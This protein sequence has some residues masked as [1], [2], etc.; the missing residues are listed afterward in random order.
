MRIADKGTMR[1]DVVELIVSNTRVPSDAK[2]DLRA[3]A[4]ATRVAEREVLR[5]CEKYGGDTVVTAFEEVQDY[6]ERLTRKRVGELPDGVWETEDYIDFDPAEGEGLVPVKVKLEIDGEDA[7]LRPLRLASGGRD[8][9][10]LGLRHDVLGHRRRHQDVLPRRA[11]EL[12]LLPR[13]RVDAGEEN[14]VVNAAWPVAVTGFCSGGYEKVTNAVYELWSQVMPDRAMACCFNL[15]YLLVGG[16]DARTDDRPVFMW[17]DWMVGGWGGRNGKDGADCT[18]P[19][20]GVGLAVQP[21]EGQER[22]TPVLTTAH[23][24]VP[25]SGGPGR[26]RGGVGVSKGG[27]LT[28]PEDAVMSYCCDRARSITWGIEGGLPSIPHGVWLRARR[29]GRVEV[30]RRD[31]L[32]RR[33]RPGRRVHAA[34]GRRRRLRRPARTRPRRGGRGRRRRLRHDR[35]RVQR[36][37]RRRQRGRRRAGRVRARL[38]RRPRRSASASAASAPAGS[39]RTPEQVAERYRDG[40]LDTMDAIRRHGVI[41][42]WGTGELLERTTEQFRAMLERRA[43]DHWNGG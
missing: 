25:D 33:R 20:F 16:R 34:L 38:R 15:E 12:R 18:S 11:A 31:V 26:F 37:R 41:L 22:L 21:L 23:Q 7:A 42:D 10:E 40:E 27:R 35:A 32:Q 29:R 1:D 14:T 3:Q 17:Y 6:V 36:L 8:V 5:L 2:G 13:D 39:R 24:I 19:V 9:P 28:E 43:A 30:P 4:E